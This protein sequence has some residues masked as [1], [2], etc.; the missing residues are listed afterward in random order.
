MNEKHKCFCELYTLCLF[1]WPR[2]P[3]CIVL[4]RHLLFSQLSCQG[5]K[6]QPA[7]HNTQNICFTFCSWVKS[8]VKSC[9]HYNQTAKSLN[10]GAWSWDFCRTSCSRLTLR[11]SIMWHLLRR[12]TN[13]Q[14]LLSKHV[15][16]WIK[17][18]E[19]I[20]SPDTNAVRRDLNFTFVNEVKMDLF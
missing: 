16:I 20:F 5:K 14:T 6:K 13:V 8:G 19:C 7:T 15:V 1:L 2:Y 10:A 17:Y 12:R 9:F 18:I 3:E 4:L 11:F